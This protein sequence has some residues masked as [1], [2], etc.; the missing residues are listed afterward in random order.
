M[1]PK[2]SK[3][4][5]K[6]EEITPTKSRDTLIMLLRDKWKMLYFYIQKF[7][8]VLNENE[9]TPPK[10]SRGVSILSVIRLLDSLQEV[11]VCIKWRMICQFGFPRE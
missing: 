9:G 2:F 10:K 11:Y 5:T 7:G 6:N 3:V 4:L 1:E 8:R